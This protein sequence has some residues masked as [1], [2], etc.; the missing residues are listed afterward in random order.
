MTNETKFHCCSE[1][2]L[3]R[4]SPISFLVYPFALRLSKTHGGRYSYP[5]TLVGEFFDYDE[6]TVQQS[7]K[8]LEKAGFF[9]RLETRFFEGNVY[10]VLSHKEWAADHPGQC[11]V[12]TT[13]P[14]TG[15]GDKLGQDLYVASGSA[16]KFYDNQIK[17]LRSLG[18]SEEQIVSEFETF[19]T[20]QSCKSNAS[21]FKS[22]RAG[23]VGRF[24][25]AMKALAGKCAL[26]A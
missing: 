17:F 15:E 8:E 3:A 23:I 21:K 19:W 14:W 9:R 24:M 5:A 16:V 7:Y 11:A 13:L 2:H 10:R 22:N 12:K 1:W 6:W 18:L 26:A 4:L 25:L 20:E